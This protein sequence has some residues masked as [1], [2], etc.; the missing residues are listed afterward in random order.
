MSSHQ[1]KKYAI[2]NTSSSFNSSNGKD[3]LDA[4]LILASYEMPVSLFFV[5]DGVY[6]VQA[7]QNAEAIAAKDYIATFKA[8]GFYD[9]KDIFVCQQSLT[10]RS[11]TTNFVVASAKTLTTSEIKQQLLNFD[12]VLTF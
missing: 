10:E 1:I 5:G 2:I 12:V 8:L 11:L 9:I 7:Q 4:A 3:S 6:Q